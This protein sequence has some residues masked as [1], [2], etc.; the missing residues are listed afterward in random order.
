MTMTESQDALAHLA[1]QVE[2]GADEA[3]LDA[4]VNRF[5]TVETEAVRAP[6]HCAGLRTPAP[7]ALAAQTPDKASEAAAAVAQAKALAESAGTL[8]ELQAALAG[9]E[10][11]ELRHGARNLVFSDGDPEARVMIVG[12]APGR[13]EDIQG[14]P[15]VGGP[16]SFW[17]RCFRPSACHAPPRM[18]P[19]PSTSPTCCPGGRR[20]TATRRPRK[21]R[22]CSPSCGKHVELAAPEVLILMGNWACFGLLGKRGIT[23][24]RGTWEEALGRP[25]LP[26]FHPAY[27]LRNPAAKREAWADLLS[28][29]A[30]LR[31]EP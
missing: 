12:E 29:K 5:E 28:L 8:P 30:K 9:F 22:C 4:P 19:K 1:W 11:C 23:R 26:M 17:T 31:G 3:I 7:A 21:S 24:M 18:H 6:R 10:A 25:A 16:G 2:L 15:F 14:K 13:D 20:R 27:L